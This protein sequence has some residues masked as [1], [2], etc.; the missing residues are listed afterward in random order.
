M[1]ASGYRA[2]ML[3]LVQREDCPGF[4]IAGDIDP[5]YAAELERAR[6]AGVETLCY[7]CK[8]TT[9]AITLDAALPLRLED[10]HG[11]ACR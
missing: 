10:A 1:V 4:A 8:L 2:V 6:A 11:H 3:Y 5:M 9:E 7:C